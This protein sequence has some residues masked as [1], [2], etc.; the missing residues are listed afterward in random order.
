M[1]VNGAMGSSIIVSML[2]STGAGLTIMGV[3]WIAAAAG[4]V[5]SVPVSCAASVE[6]AARISAPMIATAVAAA[7][8]KARNAAGLSMMR[9]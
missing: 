7:S 8:R 3:V 9:V 4:C 6:Q 5:G 1:L 2:P